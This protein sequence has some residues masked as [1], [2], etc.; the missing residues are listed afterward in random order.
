MDFKCSIESIPELVK[1]EG[2]ISS[3][4]QAW[5]VEAACVCEAFLRQ[6]LEEPPKPKYVIISERFGRLLDAARRRR[7]RR[8]A[9]RRLHRRTDWQK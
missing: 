3:S 6:A 5:R 9:L 1:L 7:R 8:S 4:I 2:Q